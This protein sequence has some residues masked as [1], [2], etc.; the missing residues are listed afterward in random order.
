ME[1][2][3]NFLYFGKRS[4]LLLQELTFPARKVKKKTILKCFL[5]FEKM[6]L[7]SSKLNNFL[8]F[9]KELIG[10]ENQKFLI[11]YSNIS[12]KE[13]GFLYVFYKE[14]KLSKLQL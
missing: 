4:F 9:R 6:E 3:K 11:F 7:S 8:N 2:Q 1:T 14:A 13:K 5:Y 12:A 10:P